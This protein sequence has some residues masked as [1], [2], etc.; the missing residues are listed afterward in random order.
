MIGT[1]GIRARLKLEV[2]YI[3]LR[4][5]SSGTENQDFTGKNAFHGFHGSIVDFTGLPKKQPISRASEHRE[6][7]RALPYSSIR[8]SIPRTFFVKMKVYTIESI[9]VLRCSQ[10]PHLSINICFISVSQTVI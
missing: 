10:D 5:D 2:N 4:F 3:H 8:H 7:G 9:Y 1:I 6:K